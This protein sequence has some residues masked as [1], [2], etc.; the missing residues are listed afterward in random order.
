LC[1]NRGRHPFRVGEKNTWGISG[2]TKKKRAR[3]RK[4]R[5]CRERRMPGLRSLGHKAETKKRGTKG[6]GTK[7][8]RVATKILVRYIPLGESQSND[9]KYAI[10]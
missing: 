7:N 10:T 4:G 9:Q 1:K 8:C 6:V 5:E 3:Y 2:K